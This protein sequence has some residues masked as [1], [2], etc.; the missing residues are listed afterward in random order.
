[1]DIQLGLAEYSQGA[2][3][4][5]K[6][7]MCVTSSDPHDSPL[8]ADANPGSLAPASVALA[9]YPICLLKFEVLVIPPQKMWQAAWMS[10]RVRLKCRFVSHQMS[11]SA[12]AMWTLALPSWSI[13]SPFPCLEN[14]MTAPPSWGPSAS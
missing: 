5:C 11:T 4:C 3:D 14:A 10:E 12:S 13:L 6:H 1:M 8:E 9:S 7:F 2:R